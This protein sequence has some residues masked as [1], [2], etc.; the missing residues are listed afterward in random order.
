MQNKHSTLVKKQFE[1]ES[2]TY[3]NEIK[4]ILPKYDKMCNLIIKNLKFKKKNIDVLDLGIGTGYITHKILDKY[5]KANVIAIDLSKK[6]MQNAENRLF[7]FKG[8]IKYI[9][10][11]M[12]YYKPKQKF[13]LIIATLSIH[14]LTAKQKQKLYIKLS[15]ALKPKGLFIIGD[16]TKGNTLKETKIIE[17]NFKKHLI[18]EFGKIKGNK[19]WK[20]LEKEDMPESPNNQLLFLS[21]A[22]FK[23]TKLIWQKDN[24]AIIISSK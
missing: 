14:H 24:L 5:S 3:D 19:Y 12:I 17:T 16:L 15:S 20:I 4:S 11:D 10:S 21:K 7:A 6:M 9:E 8:Q 23:S 1:F 22:G 13:D 2:D 18:K